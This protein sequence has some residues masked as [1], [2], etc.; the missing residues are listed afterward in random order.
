MR[1]G[2]K[3]TGYEKCCLMRLDFSSQEKEAFPATP[4]SSRRA[5]VGAVSQDNFISSL[6]TISD[7][8]KANYPV[9]LFLLA[10]IGATERVVTLVGCLCLLFIILRD[11]YQMADSSRATILYSF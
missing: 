6:G 10:V 1:H 9:L 11:S 3:Y 8:L 2:P 5:L 4:W 7:V